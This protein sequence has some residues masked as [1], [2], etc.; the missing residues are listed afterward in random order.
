MQEALQQLVHTLA[1]LTVGGHRQAARQ[2]CLDHL[3]DQRAQL[4][5]LGAEPFQLIGTGQLTL[6]Q[7][8]DQGPDNHLH[9]TG[10]Y[11]F[12]VPPNR[13]QLIE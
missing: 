5:Q 1:Q 12:D 3:F 6:Q 13:L 8:I 9:D 2:L 4:Q 11:L 10:G 7:R